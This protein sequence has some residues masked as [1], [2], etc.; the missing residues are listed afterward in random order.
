MKTRYTLVAMGA[1]LAL[2][3]SALAQRGSSGNVNIIYWQAPSILNPYL[4]TGTKDVES[5]SLVL[6]PLIRFSERGE[7]VAWLVAE[8]PTVANGGFAA[9]FKSITYK[10]KP[11]LK[12]SD[13]SPLTAA[14]VVFTYDY[15]TGIKGCAKAN[16]FT[17]VEKVTAVDANTIRIN[18]KAAAPY[19]YS[20]FGGASTPILQKAQFQDCLGDK[21]PSCT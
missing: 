12:W 15:C 11:G 10:L 6:E 19:P 17:P 1:L 3:Q 8:V 2:S 20:V 5:S 16:I 9:D 7:M 4:S 14:D 13:G 21:A 18:F